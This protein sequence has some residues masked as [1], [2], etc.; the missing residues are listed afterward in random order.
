MR[1]VRRS[2]AVSAVAVAGVFAA[3]FG[4]AALPANAEL[5]HITI[6]LL[7]GA[8][9]DI[10]VDVPPGTPL[11][12]IRILGLQGPIIGI[13]D[14]GPAAPPSPEPSPT[15]VPPAPS[16]E[17][18]PEGLPDAPRS[19][20]S[21]KQARGERQK[22]VR[23]KSD[24]DA[25]ASKVAEQVTEAAQARAVRRATEKAKRLAG[26][27]LGGVPTDDNPTFSLALPGAAP[28]GAPNFMIDKF[29]IPP[30]LLPIYQAAGIEYGIRWEVLAAINEIETDYGRNLNVCSAGALGLDAV[31]AVDVEDLRRRRQP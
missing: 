2:R 6:T 27:S 30:F 24:S 14:S 16:A 31:P 25:G 18:S 22:T 29:R 5:R 21:G 13:S 17:A 4:A 19:D 11:D 10:V 3:V 28:I 20:A 8:K 15:E 1:R 9:L 12:Q 26:R 23:R 7:G